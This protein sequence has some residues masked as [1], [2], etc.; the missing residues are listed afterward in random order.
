MPLVRASGK[1][2]RIKIKGGFECPLFCCPGTSQ[3][4]LVHRVLGARVSWVW[5]KISVRLSPY[6]PRF[7]YLGSVIHSITSTVV[8]TFLF[9]SPASLV[10]VILPPFSSPLNFRT[11]AL[12]V[13]FSIPHTTSL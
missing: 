6:A 8:F 7:N 11:V 1:R 10:L 5:G 13:L 9:S 4:F 2:I 12:N 3:G